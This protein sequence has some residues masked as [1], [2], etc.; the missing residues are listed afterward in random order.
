M[1]VPPSTLPVDRSVDHSPASAA[2]F[3]LIE[4]LTVITV[5][6]ILASFALNAMGGL[7]MRASRQSAQ[8]ELAVLARSIE[9][10]RNYYGSYPQTDQ[11][12]AL[13]AALAGYRGPRNQPLPERSRRFLDPAGL[14]LALADPDHP[15]NRV[16]DP[17]G[18][19]Y[20]YAYAPSGTW[21]APGYL[22][23]SS[24][25]DGDPGRHENGVPDPSSP[26]QAD[27]V[28]PNR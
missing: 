19:P 25:P 20:A 15:G 22:L 5:V 13:Y 26:G 7:Q 24:G 3:T 11:P 10:Y 4:L 12:E 21:L 17:W 14:T 23:Y 2:G 28:Y 18:Q 1:Q 6:A 8:V 16:L 27:N 9:G